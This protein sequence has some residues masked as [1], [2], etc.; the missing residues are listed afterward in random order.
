MHDDRWRA[1]AALVLAGV[2][3]G[4][5]VWLIWI[6]LALKAA[7][8][9]GTACDLGGYF[10]CDIVN[11]SRFASVLGVPIAYGALA[12]YVLLAAL[13]QV[14]LR[15]G[16]RLRVAAY[17]RVLGTV[18]VAY[19]AY[20]AL[21]SVTVLH[22]LCVLCVGL[23]AVNVGVAVLGWWRCPSKLSVF[24]AVASDLKL[25]RS[26]RRA[27]PVYVGLAILLLGAVGLRQVGQTLEARAAV[28]IVTVPAKSVA[29]RVAPGHGDGPS[30][31]SVVVVDFSDFACPHCKRASA[32]LAE[33]RA[34]F[35]GRVRFVFKH[36]PMEARCNRGVRRS[37]HPRACEAAEAAVCAGRQG[38]LWRFQE[39]VFA[40]GVADDQVQEAAQGAGL[41]MAAW[42]QCRWTAWA[43]DTVTADVEDG[44]RLGIHRTPTFLVG[45]R[46]LA[47]A[48]AVEE[49]RSEIE[50]Q[51]A[52]LK[53]KPGP[54][55][56]RPRGR[57]P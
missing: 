52:L 38:R 39:E 4:L 41:D 37:R 16:R 32:A 34:E 30:D 14:Q 3:A 28:P 9:S 5:A 50:R 6:H 36:F 1:V 27:W 12:M 23:Y 54:T 46:V 35:A 26:A 15:D 45:D 17:A 25:V 19:S 48:S 57:R 11:G 56:V 2:G 55:P 47:G 7:P 13:A 18:A 43:R 42:R 29:L 51:L 22:A 44:L 24:D 8:G 21:L 49:V 33:L 20:L 10:D 40:R 53:P 31:S